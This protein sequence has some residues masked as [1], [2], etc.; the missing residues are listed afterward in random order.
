MLL[1]ILVETNTDESCKVAI[2][3]LIRYHEERKDQNGK[4]C[5]MGK[6]HNILYVALKLCYIWQLKDIATV[7]SVINNN[8]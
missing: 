8:E 3:T 4:V 1:F 2:K 7:S 5:M 6:Y